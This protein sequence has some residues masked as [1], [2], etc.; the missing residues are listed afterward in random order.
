MLSIRNVQLSIMVGRFP[1]VTDF[2]VFSVRKGNAETV[3]H[4]KSRPSPL[5]PLPT[6][7]SLSSN[8]LLFKITE[9]HTEIFIYIGNDLNRASHS[10]LPERKPNTPAE[11]MTFV[12]AQDRDQY[13]A[14]YRKKR[15]ECKSCLAVYCLHSWKYLKHISARN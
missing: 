1:I 5:T 12:E 13:L 15:N 2:S 9:Y 8:V 14:S 3:P 10:V 4:T 6:H 11:Q 7:Y